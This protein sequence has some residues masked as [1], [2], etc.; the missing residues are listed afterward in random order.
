VLENELLEVEEG[1]LVVD[2]LSDLYDGAPGVFR[3]ELCAVRALR[4]GD[5]E[6]DLKDLLQDSR[7]EDL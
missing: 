7:R 4:V 2:L 6:L 5:D 1:S 3:C